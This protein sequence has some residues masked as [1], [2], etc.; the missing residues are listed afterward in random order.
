MLD[1]K[2]VQHEQD[3]PRMAAKSVG[4]GHVPARARPCSAADELEEPAATRNSHVSLALP[5]QWAR[6]PAS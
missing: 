6:T 2:V 5:R 1:T 3:Y 4:T